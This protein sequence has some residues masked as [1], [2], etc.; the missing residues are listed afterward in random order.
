MSETG[1]ERQYLTFMLGEQAYAVSIQR[2]KEIIE[3]NQLTEVPM[4]PSFIRGV[5]NLRGRV[6]PVVDLL[7]RFGKGCAQ[8]GRRTCIVILEAQSASGHQDIGIMV[9]AVNEVLGIPASDIEP[10]PT[11]GA[12]IR[13]D[14][15][16]GIGKV[17]GRFVILLAID[18]ILSIEE[19]TLLQDIAAE[20]DP[21]AVPA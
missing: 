10:S 18:H 6:V 7:G 9:D 8:V 13:A 12:Q 3:Y 20:E 19:Q 17:E 11:F 5:I 21:A 16:E 14:F 2:I 1:Q 15:I 4:M